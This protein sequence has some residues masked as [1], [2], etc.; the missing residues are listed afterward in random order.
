MQLLGTYGCCSVLSIPRLYRAKIYIC[1]SGDGFLGGPELLLRVAR[2]LPWT[3][4]LWR[5]SIYGDLKAVQ[6]M[7]ADRAASPHDI[8]PAG[9]NAL[10]HASKHRSTEL[11]VFL[12][13]QGTDVSQPDNL[14]G[15]ASERFLKRSFGGMYSDNDAII[16]RILKGDDSFDE[17]GFMTLHKIV[18]GFDMRE[19]QVVLDATTD[20][21]NVPDSLG[22]TCLFWAVFR[23]N[24]EHVR[25][26]L[27]YGADPNVRDLRDFTPLDFVRGP[28]ACQLLLAHDAKMNINPKNYH[29][30]SV[31]EHVLENGC[32]N[33]IDVFASTGFD[34]DIRDIDDE[35]PLLNAIHRGQTAV[36]KR[37]LELGANVNGANKS[38]RDSA[39]HFAAHCDRPDIL[40]ML[41][42]YGAD[43]TV[44]ECYGRNLA[45]CAAKT[46]S[47]EFFKVM[48]AA[49][50][51][52]LDTKLKDDH[53]KTP[54][55]YIESRIVMTDREVGMHEAWEEFVTSL[56]PSQL[57]TKVTETATVGT[58]VLDLGENE[59]RKI[60]WRIPGAF[61]ITA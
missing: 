32:P 14:G 11:A 50:M 33:A 46:G 8:D 61:P 44:L 54:G 22:R 26:L 16:R 6:K 34:V 29:R 38:S 25:I 20:T 35:T 17:F 56:A 15:T 40:R 18:L 48:T 58:T 55:E 36:A 43:Y 37:L 12:L 42:A 28:A 24:V 51:K 2:V 27:S 47:T 19:L 13:D 10:V 60:T 49:Q 41:L 7:F 30:S 23:D 52:G 39:I 21:L 4:L 45:H 57:K 31:H 9:R 5:Y 1:G 59:Q 3:H 53:G